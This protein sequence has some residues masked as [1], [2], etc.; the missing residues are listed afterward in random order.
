MVAGVYSADQASSANRR[1]NRNA[2]EIAAQEADLARETLEY[3]KLRDSQSAQLQ[4]Q[5]N[6]IAG[7]VANS[8][9]ALMDQQRRISGEYH[10]RNKKVFWPLENQIVKDAKNYDTPQRREAEAGRSIADVET[11]IN[12]E[13]QM[14]NRANQRMGVNPSSGNALAMNNQLSLG[15]A[16]LKAG[17]AGLARDR[18]ETQGFARRMDAASLGR[19]LASAQAT[20]ASTSTQAGNSAVNAA[21]AP[22]QAANQQTQIMGAALGNYGNSMSN[23]NRLMYSNQQQEAA[24]WG[25]AAGSFF[26][27]AGSL[28]GA[29]AAGKRN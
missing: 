17:A 23:A 1:N 4:A 27:S 6:A 18:V 15:A 3:Y 7:R 29:Y 14:M 9:V 8:Q 13:R 12:A 25:Q 11:S 10:D 24:Q 22:V 2:A 19:G 21:Y 5:A 16:S 28:L 26:D 20:A